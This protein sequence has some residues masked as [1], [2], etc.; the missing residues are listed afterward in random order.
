MPGAGTLIDD[1]VQLLECCCYCPLTKENLFLCSG[2]ATML[3]S[4]RECL[5][6][7]APF[8]EPD[9]LRSGSGA[10]SQAVTESSEDTDRFVEYVHS[11][12]E[13]IVRFLDA[14]PES[15]V[16]ADQQHYQ[17]CLDAYQNPALAQQVINEDDDL[18][19]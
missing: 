12:A 13:S 14:L 11:M 16:P 7:G 3:E 10:G 1:S 17:R 15:V 18:G 2:D 5:D 8:K 4:I 6:T 9:E 19:S